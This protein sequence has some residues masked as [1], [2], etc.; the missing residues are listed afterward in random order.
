MS[1]EFCDND[2]SKVGG[3]FERLALRLR[4][5]PDRSVEDE[6]RHVRLDGRSDLDHLFE[7]I[8]L[9]TMA[10]RSVHDDDLEPVCTELGDTGGGNLDR[11]G[12][13]VAAER[14]GSCQGVFKQCEESITFH[15]KAPWL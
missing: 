14:E 8:A 10:S 9:L 5:L 1:V 3:L 13:S 12:L 11:V 4:S 6:D 7:K 15:K 2:S